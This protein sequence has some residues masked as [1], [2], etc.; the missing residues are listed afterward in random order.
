MRSF[1][2]ALIL[3]LAVGQAVEAGPLLRFFR[4]R[5][6]GCC[7]SATASSPASSSASNSCASGTRRTR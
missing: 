2:C 4:G 1:L 7:G 6:A 3:L 5:R